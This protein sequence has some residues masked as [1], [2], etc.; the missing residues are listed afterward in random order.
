MSKRDGPH[1]LKSPPAPTCRLSRD[2]SLGFSIREVGA[3]VTPHLPQ[4]TSSHGGRGV[5]QIPTVPAP[6]SGLSHWASWAHFHRDA[7]RTPL[8]TWPTL[9]LEEL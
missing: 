7:P 5:S 3:L 1:L 8:V 9:S 6:S 4:T 2:S